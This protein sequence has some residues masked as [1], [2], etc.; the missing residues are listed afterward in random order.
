MKSVKIAGNA[1]FLPAVLTRWQFLP[2]RHFPQFRVGNPAP[3]E[4]T[5]PPRGA[6]ADFHD[7]WFKNFSA[8]VRL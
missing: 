8:P 1:E 4:T 6:R 2:D 7:T 3:E 5:L